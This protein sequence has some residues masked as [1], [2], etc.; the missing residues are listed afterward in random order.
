[1]FTT[2]PRHLDR[3]GIVASA[4]CIA[5]CL[6]APTLAVALPL[7]AVNMAPESIHRPLAL[8]L[9]LLAPFAALAGYRRHERRSVPVLMGAGL[10]LVLFAA[11][12]ES[13]SLARVETAVSVLGSLLLVAGHGLNLRA[14]RALA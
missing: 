13:A 11:F 14:A 5:H 4:V 3:A 7:V 9:C 2:S 12:N 6:A 8:L 1:M 10:L